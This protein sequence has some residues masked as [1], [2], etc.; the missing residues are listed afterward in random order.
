[1]NNLN[2]SGYLHMY[3]LSDVIPVVNGLVANESIYSNTNVYNYIAK[4]WVC[5]GVYGCL[6]DEF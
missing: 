3:L 4:K 1:M 2:I 6:W 5:E